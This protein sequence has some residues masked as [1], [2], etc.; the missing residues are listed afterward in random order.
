MTL[1]ST[2]PILYHCGERN[3]S[4]PLE[5]YNNV[6][7][8]KE[9]I[10][11]IPTKHRKKGGFILGKTMNETRLRFILLCPSL[12]KTNKQKNLVF[13]WCQYKL[14]SLLYWRVF[15]RPAL[16]KWTKR[17]IRVDEGQLARVDRFFESSLEISLYISIYTAC[18]PLGHTPGLSALLCARRSMPS[19]PLVKG[20]ETTE[21]CFIVVGLLAHNVYVE[22]KS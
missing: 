3:L 13:A 21:L 19:D 14:C 6:F 22:S 10:R 7:R 12:S 11:R 8:L 1:S 9:C 4:T 17:L 15:T 16:F 20:L 18:F 2:V 5:T